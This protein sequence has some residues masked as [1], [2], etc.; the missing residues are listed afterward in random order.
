MVIVLKQDKPEIVARQLEFFEAVGNGLVPSHVRSRRADAYVY[1]WVE[2]KEA[3]SIIHVE[4]LVDILKRSVWKGSDEIGS[5]STL[6]RLQ[7]V[8]YVMAKAGRIF[9]EQELIPIEGVLWEGIVNGELHGAQQVHGDLTLE[10]VIVRSSLTASPQ[11]AI[12]HDN[13]GQSM[14]AMGRNSRRIVHDLRLVE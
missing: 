6:D 4:M 3:Y 13:M 9:K 10:N 1:E 11:P 12:I 2:G 8:R 5:P 7:Y 14:S